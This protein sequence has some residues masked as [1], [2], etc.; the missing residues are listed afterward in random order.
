MGKS[1]KVTPKLTVQVENRN[2]ANAHKM[3]GKSEKS[4]PNL[5]R[6]L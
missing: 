1:G 3:S 4:R 2:Q 6:I 5:I